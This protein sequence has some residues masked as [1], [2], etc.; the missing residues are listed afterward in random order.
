MNDLV[1]ATAC[2]LPALR[3]TP[4]LVSR[5]IALPTCQYVQNKNKKDVSSLRAVTV[6]AR[7]A[8]TFEQYVALIVIVR[9]SAANVS[10]DL[11]EM[12]FSRHTKT[13][14]VGQWDSGT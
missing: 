13:L 10:I 4:S 7:L 9:R 1:D 2:S 12:P 3:Y 11:I 14:M 5:A 8:T 6:T